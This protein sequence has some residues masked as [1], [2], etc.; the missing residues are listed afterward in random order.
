[1]CLPPS[2]PSPTRRMAVDKRPIYG[3]QT[4]V[5]GGVLAGIYATTPAQA[6][7]L[8]RVLVKAMQ[9]FA[10]RHEETVLAKWHNELERIRARAIR[11]N[12]TGWEE[13]ALASQKKGDRA[14]G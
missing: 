8:Q 10:G 6:R 7:L 13:P 2:A 4:P 9:D 14:D 11:E 3:E 1:M 12:W 5:F